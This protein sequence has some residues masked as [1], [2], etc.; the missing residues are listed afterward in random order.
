MAT[1]EILPFATGGSAN[2][3]SQAAYAADSTTTNGFA[4][5]IAISQKLNKVWRQSS[6]MAS[7]FANWMVSQSVSVP[8]DGNLSAL[9]SNIGT[10]LSTLIT[11]KIRRTSL[12][13]NTTFYIATTGNNTNAGTVGS[14]WL[15]LQYAWDYI[16]NN[17]D[18]AGFTATIQL[19]DGT[20]T[21]GLN[22]AN[23]P[24]GIIIINGNS[25]TPTNVI[26]STSATAFT[27]TGPSNPTIQNMKVQTTGTGHEGIIANYGATV[28]VL[29]LTFGAV[30]N[31]CLRSTANSQIIQNG[32]ITFVGSAVGAYY[33]DK[34]GVII[35]ISQTITFTGAIAFSA[36]TVQSVNGYVELSA[37]TIT[38][39]S[40]TG[41][42]Y[43]V[44]MNGVINTNGGGA[45]FIPGNAAGT[46]VTGGQYI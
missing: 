25:G 23:I 30:A 46:P 15:T 3:E 42:R 2:V 19:A 6:F 10:A 1:T 17:I 12:I 31:Y 13:A 29:N 38:G 8:D 5:G 14:P 39:A 7:G 27:I 9:A 34:Q 26:V 41:T 33:A 20:Y 45:S 21:S 35:A 22:A 40:V 16:A 32:I 37:S 43:A 24:N 28:N 11:S 36:A 18:M 44:A 4:A